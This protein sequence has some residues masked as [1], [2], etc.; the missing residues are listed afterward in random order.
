MKSMSKFLLIV[1]GLCPVLFSSCAS[2]GSRAETGAILFS[3]A[4]TGSTGGTGKASSTNIYGS[5][6]PSMA[7]YNPADLEFDDAWLFAPD[8]YR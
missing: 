1:A 3:T 7:Y 8:T 4:S 6:L 5:S 2:P